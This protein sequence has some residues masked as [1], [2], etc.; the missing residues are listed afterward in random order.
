MIR[1]ASL[2]AVSF[3]F[4]MSAQFARTA[5]KPKE[6]PVALEKKLHGAWET[7][8]MDCVGELTLRADGTFERQHFSPGSNKL[9]GTW[10][11]RWD[12][13]PPTLVMSCNASNDAD[14]VG[15]T[16][17]FKVTRLDDE[18]LAYQFPGY[19]PPGEPPN[20]GMHRYKR[21]KK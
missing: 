21:V 10:E 13:L 1:M 16:W 4:V 3:A 6:P 15:R 20:P 7:D 19:Q 17:E 12:A 2:L 9:T 14:F 8:D 5:G 11:V 18:N